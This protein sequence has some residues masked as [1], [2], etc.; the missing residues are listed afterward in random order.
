MSI[1]LLSPSTG[2]RLACAFFALKI[3]FRTNFQC[4]NKDKA[5]NDV[6]LGKGGIYITSSPTIIVMNTENIFM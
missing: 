3:R 4:D 5:M 6:W 1:V 2:F